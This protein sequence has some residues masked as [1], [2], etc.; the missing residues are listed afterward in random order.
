MKDIATTKKVKKDSAVAKLSQQIK[1]VTDALMTANVADEVKGMIPEVL[2][3]SLG[4][5]SD[6][7]HK[8]QEEVIENIANIMNDVEAGLTKEVDETRAKHEEALSGKP[9][10]EKE[11][12]DALAQLEAAKAETQRLKVALAGVATAFRNAQQSLVDAEAAK[13]LDAQ[14][15]IEASKKKGHFENAL[16]DLKFLKMAALDDAEAPGR[17]S[18]LVSMLKKYKFE[19]S[20]LI[21]LPAALAKAP[22]SRGQFDLMAIAQLEGE[23][24][25]KIEEQEAILAAAKPE[26]DKCDAVVQRAQ[27]VLK[28]ARADQREAAKK[29]DT[30]SANQA[31]REEASTAAQK[32]VKDLTKLSDKLKRSVTDA[33]VGV[34]L[35]QQGPKES[36]QCLRARSTPEPVPEAVAMEQEAEPVTEQEAP[37]PAVAVC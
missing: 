34:E 33:E 10:R 31:A 4:E 35:F 28:K 22:E 9:V 20:M 15:S 25:K 32:A 37:V 2:T 13:K 17:Q 3:Y 30:A 8:Y 23:I 5:F 36:F 11:A 1:E 27:D 14:K 16:D 29:F 6:K 21:A 7:R 18:G 19:E 12:A 26:Q 24:S